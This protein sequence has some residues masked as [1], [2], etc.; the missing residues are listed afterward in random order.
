[1]IPKANEADLE[2]VPEE[3]RGLLTFHAVETLAEVFALALVD[4]T[5]AAAERVLAE[6]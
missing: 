5:A 2:D 1:V 4:S 3:V 6:V